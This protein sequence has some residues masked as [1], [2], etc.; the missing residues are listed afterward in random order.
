MLCL[1]VMVVYL[2]VLLCDTVVVVCRT[3]VYCAGWCWWSICGCCCVTLLLFLW[4]GLLCAVLAG[5]G[6]LPVGAVL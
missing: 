1:L 6:G 2:R 3:A 5:D 4:A